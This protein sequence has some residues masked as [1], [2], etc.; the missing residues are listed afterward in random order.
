MADTPVGESPSSREVAKTHMSRS[1]ATV[2]S[3]FVAIAI[4]A[5]GCGATHST[6]NPVVEPTTSTSEPQSATTEAT[7]TT[8]ESTP[9]DTS[10]TESSSSETSSTE[11]TP[12]ETTTTS[13]TTARL[14]CT[15]I[16]VS[17]APSP[18]GYGYRYTVSPELTGP[19]P[20]D[21]TLFAHVVYDNGAT[22]EKSDTT[23]SLWFR[24]ASY[25]RLTSVSMTV[26]TS[27][28]T[29]DCGQR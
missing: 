8:T 6:S 23:E 29:I 15:G 5:S 12:T 3:T 7:S 13:T 10:T 4:V 24:H 21:A 27:S 20:A 2:V 1:L 25:Q 26:E 11:S 22:D 28:G 19:L 14:S 9:S 17:D 18:D 16:Q